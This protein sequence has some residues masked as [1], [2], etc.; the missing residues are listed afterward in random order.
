MILSSSYQP[1]NLGKT[2]SAKRRI[3]TMPKYT[4]HCHCR[5]VEYQIDITGKGQFRESPEYDLCTDCNRVTGSLMVPPTIE[6]AK[7]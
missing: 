5:S 3:I 6:S 4:G 2:T 1:S 7:R